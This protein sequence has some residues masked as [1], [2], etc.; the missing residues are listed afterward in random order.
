MK[1][2]DINFKRVFPWSFGQVSNQEFTF[3]A[4][5]S[6]TLA[7]DFLRWN[8]A[9]DTSDSFCM[10]T[11]EFA[12]L[13]H[14]LATSKFAAALGKTYC[15]LELTG[16]NYKTREQDL[17]VISI[18]NKFDPKAAIFQLPLNLYTIANG[19]DA[20]TTGIAAFTTIA[21][22]TDRGLREQ[23]LSSAKQSFN[24]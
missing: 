7:I 24:L 2:R 12:L 22:V 23:I 18:E 17:Y 9:Q 15:V 11:L 21:L 19:I 4:S 13:Q 14:Q 10:G 16:D 1:P 20:R 3:K 8:I 6:G 5:F